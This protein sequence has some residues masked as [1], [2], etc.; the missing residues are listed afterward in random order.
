MK[1][2]PTL[3]VRDPED[4]RSVLPTVTPGCEWVL[5]GEGTATRKWDGTCTMLSAS[6]DWWARREV[7]PGKTPPERFVAVE[8]DET[9]GKTVGWEPIAGSSF[10]KYHAEAVAR[11]GE[12]MPGTYELLGPK[13]NGNPERFAG[14]ILI[15]HGWARF[16]ERR[17]L[18]ATPRDYDGL[19]AWLLAHPTWEGIVWHHPDGR[20]AKLKRRDFP[21][22]ARP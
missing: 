18:T 17:E 3:F 5:D 8:H 14:H 6:G 9:T 2:I 1:K 22:G 7:K 15:A 12:P 21:Q 13:I 4:R 11:D 16:S 20:M 10:A 19:R